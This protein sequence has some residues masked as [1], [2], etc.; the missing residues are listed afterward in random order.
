MDNKNKS[1]MA[2]IFSYGRNF[3][4]KYREIV[5]YIKSKVKSGQI[6]TGE[7]IIAIEELS[8]K[9][10]CD[11]ETVSRA[12]EEMHGVGILE[13]KEDGYF[14]REDYD[15]KLSDGIDFRAVDIKCEK[16][17]YLNFQYCM[18]KVLEEGREEIMSY[19][20]PQ[21]LLELRRT[22]AKVIKERDVNVDMDDMVI[23]TGTQQALDILTRMDFPNN[24]KDAL[25]EQPTY[26][27]IIKALEHSKKNII[28]IDRY[29][30]GMDF[31][32]LEELFKK[33]DIKFF[34]TV[35]KFSNPMGNSYTEYERE[36]LC[37]L[38]EKYDVY[39]IEDDSFSD[40]E[41]FSNSK[42][43]Y[44]LDNFERVIYIKSFSK[45]LFPGIRLA[46]VLLPSN[47]K[48]KFLK[49]KKWMDLGSCGIMQSTLE[50]YIQGG[51][52]DEHIEILKEM[53]HLK[54]QKLQEASEE[55]KRGYIDWNIPQGGMFASM[56]INKN[57]NID[58]IVKRTKER[59]VYIQNLKSCFLNNR[60]HKN[61]IR[62]SLG[63]AKEEKIKEGISIIIEEIEKE[64]SENK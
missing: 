3:M 30:E 23:T 56:I 21:G 58:N 41:V 29:K 36:I 64:I 50:M 17:A 18:E 2:L 33:E 57:I 14:I 43:I 45:S 35:P 20:N 37:N 22:L 51:Y 60:E 32:K 24:K 5:A 11:L 8:K 26:V 15:F 47:M 42:P 48:K 9:F 34:Y 63:R 39:I 7:K 25:I 1:A 12:I 61:F 10:N 31:K 44:S 52:F 19:I 28:G 4:Y 53:M 55:F 6:K 13:W 59:G 62:I 40:F 38:A 16:E 49:I 46:L 54:M 27:G